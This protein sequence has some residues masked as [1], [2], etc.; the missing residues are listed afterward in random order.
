MLRQMAATEKILS[1]S[2]LTLPPPAL[3]S[4]DAKKAAIVRTHP[5]A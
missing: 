5:I 1:L 3:L 2:Q 4:V